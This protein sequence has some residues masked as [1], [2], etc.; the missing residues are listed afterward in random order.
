MTITRFLLAGS[1]VLLLGCPA[2]T[3]LP[4]AKTAATVSAVVPPQSDIV[5]GPLEVAVQ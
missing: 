2:T 4:P 1:A 3:G 5:C